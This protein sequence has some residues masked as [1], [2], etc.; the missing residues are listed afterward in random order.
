[1]TGGKA[2]EWQV[3][4]LRNDGKYGLPEHFIVILNLIQDLCQRTTN[5]L[6]LQIT[7]LHCRVTSVKTIRI[8]IFSYYT[9]RANNTIIANAHTR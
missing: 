2:A 9:T 6:K 7:N 1:M 8:N 3:G 5:R 4:E